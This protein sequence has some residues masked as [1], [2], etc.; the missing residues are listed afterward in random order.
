M[1]EMEQKG[2]QVDYNEVL[3]NIRERDRIDTTREVSP[4]RKADDAHVLDNDNLTREQQMDRLLQLYH[5]AT[6]TVN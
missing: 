3:A 5:E 4:L 6:D 2:E 1:L